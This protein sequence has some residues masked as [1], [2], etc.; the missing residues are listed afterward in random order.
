MDSLQSNSSLLT[1]HSSLLLSVLSHTQVFLSPP[2]HELIRFVLA[3]LLEIAQ[4]GLLEHLGGV[5]V[6]RVRAPGRLRDDLIDHTK[7]VEVLRGDA[8]RTGGALL[9][10]W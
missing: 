7:L 9:H 4:Q 2:A 5:L 1:S 6:V 10:H 8:Q 3:Q